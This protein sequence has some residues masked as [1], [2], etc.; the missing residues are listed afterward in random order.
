MIAK[1]IA[2]IIMIILMFP[3]VSY[4]S[5][6]TFGE[7][8]GRLPDPYTFRT[9]KVKVANPHYNKLKERRKKAEEMLIEREIQ[10]LEREEAQQLAK[11]KRNLIKEISSLNPFILRINREGIARTDI[12]RLFVQR[13]LHSDTWSKG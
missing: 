9:I 6:L 13:I 11:A 8:I 2:I 4:A 7:T 5:S 3:S 12:N 10:R 1:M